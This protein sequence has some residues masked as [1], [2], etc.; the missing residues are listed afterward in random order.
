MG[1]PVGFYDSEETAIREALA[2]LDGTGATKG[3]QGRVDFGSRTEAWLERVEHLVDGSSAFV[4]RRPRSREG[5]V[6]VATGR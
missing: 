1:A 4:R 2:S 6:P 5:R 3:N